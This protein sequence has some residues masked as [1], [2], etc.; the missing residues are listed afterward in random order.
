M[1][2]GALFRLLHMMSITVAFA[3]Q[4]FEELGIVK[5]YPNTLKLAND[6]LGLLDC[7]GILL[8]P[9]V[10]PLIVFFQCRCSEGTIPTYLLVLVENVLT[11]LYY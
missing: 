11:P 9:D 2:V 8:V 5:T 7:H 6:N 1:T 4:I 3:Q 10:F